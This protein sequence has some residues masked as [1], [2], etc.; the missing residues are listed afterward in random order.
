[1]KKMTLPLFAIIA[2]IFLVVIF[3]SGGPDLKQYASLSDPGVTN[4][5]P[6]KMLSIE[7]KGDPSMTSGEAFGQ[8]YKTYFKL[9]SK[10]KNFKP[11][12]PRARWTGDPADR[13]SL[14]GVFGLPV[15]DDVTGL[16]AGTDPRLRLETWNYG[17]TAQ[18][19][20][21]GA[22]TNEQ[23]T[24]ERLR[25]FIKEKGYRIVG[26]H[27]EEYLTAPSSDSSRFFT[28]IRYRVEKTGQ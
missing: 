3:R 12:A 21:K 16:P 19:L 6:Q 11:V 13:Q 10:H 25:A 26:E 17:T 9:K 8:L 22:Y 14:T 20:H 2:I 23:P 5:N 28:I 1:M 15:A 4:L 7:L 27:E 24:V 18:I